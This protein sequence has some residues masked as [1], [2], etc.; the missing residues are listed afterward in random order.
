[1][2]GR[3]AHTAGTGSAPVDR[4]H[5]HTCRQGTR[6][7]CSHWRLHTPGRRGPQCRGTR[8]SDAAP[9][10]RTRGRRHTC[11][12]SAAC[13]ALFRTA[14]SCTRRRR[15]R[16]DPLSPRTC[17]ADT[18]PRH[19]CRG[20]RGRPSSSWPCRPPQ[21]TRPRRTTSGRAS[22]RRRRPPPC[23]TPRCRARRRRRGCQ[24]TARRVGGRP[25]TRRGRRCSPGP[26]WPCMRPPGTHP[27]RRR[28]NRCKL[29]RHRHCSRHRQTSCRG[30]CGRRCS[31][32][33]R[34]PQM[35]PEGRC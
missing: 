33:C 7:S 16:C 17:L 9:P 3:T 29:C 15:R 27:P 2:T 13:M 19:T 34:S 22:M 6:W 25:G 4:P 1:M 21:D 14:R 30:T 31:G 20:R 11:G 12:C 8:R 5:H 35:F 10:G 32:R 28:G 26:A 24:R 23:G 18:A